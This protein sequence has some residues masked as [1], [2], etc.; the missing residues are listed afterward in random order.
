MGMNLRR[1]GRGN[2]EVGRLMIRV[3][4]Y[5][6]LRMENEYLGEVVQ[7]EQQLYDEKL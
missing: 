5:R 2:E 1:K 6:T 4:E 3:I 7:G